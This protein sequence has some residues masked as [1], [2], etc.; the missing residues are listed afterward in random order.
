MRKKVSV[1]RL[2]HA[3]S[4]PIATWVGDMADA[5]DRSLLSSKLAESPQCVEIT[6]L[7]P[8]DGTLRP[9]LDT[10]P[11]RHRPLSHPL[12]LPVD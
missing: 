12:L 3:Q 1:Q 5:T 6:V 10:L 8:H 9:L 11:E 4:E 2:V 7:W